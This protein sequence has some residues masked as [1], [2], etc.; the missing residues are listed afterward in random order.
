GLA[1][2]VVMGGAVDAPGN[3]TPT[4][5]FNIHVDPEAAAVVLAAGLTLDLVPPGA[6]RQAVLP[7][8]DLDAAL[9]RRPGPVAQRIAAFTN[10]ALRVDDARGSTGMPP[11]DPLA[12]AAAL[13]SSLLTWEAVRLAVE[14]DG[15]TRRVAGAP[16]CRFAR[17]V[18]VPRFLRIFLE[19]L[20]PAS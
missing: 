6:P 9:R 10:Y 8:A 19:R 7:R 11:H 12:V 2:V 16:N 3:V 5:E 20:C 13:D 1:R 4:A 15:Q 17:G 18:D 14:P